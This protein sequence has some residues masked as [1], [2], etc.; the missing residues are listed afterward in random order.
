MTVDFRTQR[1]TSGLLSFSVRGL[2]AHRQGGFL[3]EAGATLAVQ[4][5][6]DWDPAR[7]GG[8]GDAELCEVSGAGCPTQNRVRVAGVRAGLRG[9][10]GG[11]LS[12]GL[13]PKVQAPRSE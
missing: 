8:R 2:H 7:R 4:S 3:P 11:R 10:S 5:G 9:S 1:H 12:A 6:R 13:L